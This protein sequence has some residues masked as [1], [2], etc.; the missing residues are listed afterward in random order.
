MCKAEDTHNTCCVAAHAR[1]LPCNASH[2]LQRCKQHQQQQQQQQQAKRSS[3][4][5]SVYIACCCLLCPV[6]RCVLWFPTGGTHWQS[7]QQQ[8]RAAAAAARAAASAPGTC[9]PH[10]S[11]GELREGASTVLHAE[12][13]SIS[14]P[15]SSLAHHGSQAL[16]LLTACIAVLIFVCPHSFVR[17]AVWF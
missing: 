13:T 3:S 9:T 14:Y 17:G 6:S 4:S 15:H 11:N 8:H 1:A 5:S 2:T 7:Q 10:T 12:G 16:V